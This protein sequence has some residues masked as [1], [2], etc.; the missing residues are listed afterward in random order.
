MKALI[1]HGTMGSPAGNW[2]PWIESELRK[3]SWEVSVPA[4]PTPEN[5]SLESWLS[6]AK[7]HTDIDLVIGHSLGATLALHLLEQNIFE[8]KQT[9]LV[10][11]VSKDIGNEAYDTLNNSF[12]KN[13]FDWLKIKNNGSNIHILHG[14]DDPYVPLS[15]AEELAENL[16][17]PLDTIPNGGHLNAEN[18]YTEF[19][20]LLNIIN[21]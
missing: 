18:G 1:I 12:I 3:K 20:H 11:T 8:S 5:Q 9:I 2:F 10:S 7:N 4:F 19:P 15:H 14:D 17:L 6:V 16:K 21:D 13:G